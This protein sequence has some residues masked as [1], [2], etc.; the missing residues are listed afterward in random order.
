MVVDVKVLVLSAVYLRSPALSSW[1][2]PGEVRGA[3]P[4]MWQ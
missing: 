3:S 2:Q 4:G 1:P